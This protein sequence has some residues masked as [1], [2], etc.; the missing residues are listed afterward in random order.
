MKAFNWLRRSLLKTN[1][2]EKQSGREERRVCMRA[3]IDMSM[4]E[5]QSEE[6]YLSM[7]HSLSTLAL[8]Y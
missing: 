2:G 1:V 3:F 4:C 5:N 6:R 8:F 7:S